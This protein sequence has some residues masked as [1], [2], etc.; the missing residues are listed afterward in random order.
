[1]VDRGVHYL[2]VLLVSLTMT[3][4]A[5][6]RS[7]ARIEELDM[8]MKKHFA[9]TGTDKL[10]ETE[11]QRLAS[12][13]SDTGTYSEYASSTFGQLMSLLPR[14][15]NVVKR[16]KAGNAQLLIMQVRM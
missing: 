7:V 12:N 8:K 9:V 13:S 3:L 1:M 4:S 10:P 5:G 16:E 14:S 15:M 11:M 2:H 6:C